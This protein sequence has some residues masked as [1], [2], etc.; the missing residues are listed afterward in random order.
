MK[1][2]RHYESTQTLLYCFIF[3]AESG[4]HIDFNKIILIKLFS[5]VNKLFIFNFFSLAILIYRMFV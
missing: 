5:I 4:M 1:K 3:R 2:N